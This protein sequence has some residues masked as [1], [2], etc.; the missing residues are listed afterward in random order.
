MVKTT[1]TKAKER[2]LTT[3]VS[4]AQNDKGYSALHLAVQKKHEDVVDEL[5]RSKVDVNT[6]LNERS[7]IEPSKEDGLKVPG[8]NEGE[9]PLM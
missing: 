8:I 2:N 9:T 4:N 7:N 1:L 3:S 5:L 6:S